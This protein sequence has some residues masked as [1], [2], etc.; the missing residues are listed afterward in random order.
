M[1]DFG[2]ALAG[3]GTALPAA[4]KDLSEQRLNMQR[5]SQEAETFAINKP[6][7]EAKANLEAAA[8]KDKLDA[9]M[10]QQADRNMPLN[11]DKIAGASK[12]NAMLGGMFDY[13]KAIGVMTDD[14]KKAGGGV[15]TKGDLADLQSGMKDNPQ[16]V[17]AVYTKRQAEISQKIQSIAG[18][19]QGSKDELVK[20]Q[21]ELAAAKTLGEQDKLKKHIEKLTGE[22]G[23]SEKAMGPLNQQNEQLLNAVGMSDSQSKFMQFEQ[24]NTALISGLSPA[25]K[26][27]YNLMKQSGDVS[28]AAGMFSKIAEEQGKAVKPPAGVEEFEMVT[29]MSAVKRGTKEYQS[30]YLEWKKNEKQAISIKVGTGGPAISPNTD[31]SLTGDAALGRYSPWVQSTAKKLAHGEIPYPQGFVLKDPQ[32]KQV[33]Q[34]ASE[35]D[36]DFNAAN[37]KIRAKLRESFTSGT[38]SKNINS[39]NTLV[40]H[41]EALSK[42][43]DGLD[44]GRIP[45]WNKVENLTT[46]ATGGSRVKKFNMDLGA[47]ES[48]LATVFKNTGAT[49]QEIKAWRE[50]ISA[51]DSPAQLHAEIQEAIKLMS[52]RLEALRN[53]YYSG[54]G[55]TAKK[56][57]I[58]SPKSKKI[59]QGMGVDVNQLDP[60][61]QPD[62]S[63]GSN[64]GKGGPQKIGRF[65]VEAQ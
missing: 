24:E 27:A 55:N 36:H 64:N 4:F 29:G 40:G 46:T 9:Y 17:N 26:A 19:L 52:S 48:E 43:A 65:T 1:S 42:S 13:A 61:N 51:A 35:Y 11:M 2:A 16:I 41:L 15:F 45:I 63:S 22:I 38:D 21:G 7:L 54:M 12:D 49:D 44:N 14:G 39:I 50:R 59:L 31:P 58:L 32:W 56:L 23:A 34:A 33:L 3:A 5:Q 37:Y 57:T 18:P 60:D 20:L 8:D 47:V 25:Q 53:K 30:K 28:G 6:A 10:K 62:D